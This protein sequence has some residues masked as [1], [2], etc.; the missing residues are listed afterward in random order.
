MNLPIPNVDTALGGV[1][2]GGGLLLAVLLW[3][4]VRAVRGRKRR[5]E[6]SAEDADRRKADAATYLA[7][8][9]ASG[10][11][12]LGMW[13]VVTVAV[14]ESGLPE[15]LHT[16]AAVVVLGF[17]EVAV[18][19]SGQRARANVRATGSTGVDG[20]ALWAL[21]ALSVAAALTQAQSLTG[22]M[23]KA[24][25][26]V[27]AAWMWERGLA[28]ERRAHRTARR[29]VHWRIGVRRIAVALRLAE[30]EETDLAVRA[31]ARR[32]GR[33]ATHI[34]R[35]QAH[36]GRR[37]RWHLRRAERALIRSANRGDFRR[38]GELTL[39]QHVGLRT[40]AR[41]LAATQ[42]PYPA[43]LFG[44]PTT[45]R[46]TICTT[47]LATV[48][49]VPAKPKPAANRPKPIR[50]PSARANGKAAPPPKRTDAEVLAEARQLTAGWAEAALTAERL[51][52]ELRIAP[53]RAQA[54]RDALRAERSGATPVGE[55]VG[56]GS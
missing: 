49:E 33:I 6:L 52:T 22:A 30:P 12:L 14:S 41:R 37:G 21:V 44:Q 26:P 28:P 50:K 45:A 55:L 15:K 32:L 1:L 9:L 27:V 48:P 2:A 11:A 5:P 47:A 3:M 18:L 13:P 43:D 20:I 51:R 16:P 54:V 25:A 34:A 40:A 42:A 36:T 39:S 24:A 10:L 4:A 35:A 31:R 19:A 56:V 23:V 8:L 46:P 53:K 38:E 17:V 29:A 7:A